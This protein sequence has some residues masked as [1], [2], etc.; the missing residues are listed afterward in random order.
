MLWSKYFY[1]FPECRALTPANRTQKEASVLYSH[2][3]G[4]SAHSGCSTYSWPCSQVLCRWLACGLSQLFN[5][6]VW[7]TVEASNGNLW[8]DKSTS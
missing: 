5:A 1:A 4:I 6:R 2:L 7:H 3:V 8:E